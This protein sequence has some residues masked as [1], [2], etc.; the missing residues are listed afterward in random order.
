MLIIRQVSSIIAING[1]LT[2][3]IRNH[4]TKKSILVKWFGV[5]KSKIRRMAY[6]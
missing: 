4:D 6:F 5:I 3:P 1:S 2:V